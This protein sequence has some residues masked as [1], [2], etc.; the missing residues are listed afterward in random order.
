MTLAT[1]VARVKLVNKISP[2]SIVENNC[3]Q[4]ITLKRNDI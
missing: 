3:M 4:D 2:N 1:F